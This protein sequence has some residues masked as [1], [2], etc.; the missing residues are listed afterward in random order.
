[1]RGTTSL[2]ERFIHSELASLL[3]ANFGRPLWECRGRPYLFQDP[4]RSVPQPKAQQ[5]RRVPAS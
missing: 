2:R 1:M 4:N 5:E 3:F